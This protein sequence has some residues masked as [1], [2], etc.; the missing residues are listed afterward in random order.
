MTNNDCDFWNDLAK[1]SGK[2]SIKDFLHT[3]EEMI[4]HLVEEVKGEKIKNV[5]KHKGG[6]VIVYFKDGGWL[7]INDKIWGKIKDRI[8]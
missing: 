1:K 2:E 3:E 8:Q 5:E 4:D 7:G 6:A